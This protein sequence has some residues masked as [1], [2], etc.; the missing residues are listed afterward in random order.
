MWRPPGHWRLAQEA[1]RTGA[2]IALF[3]VAAPR[4]LSLL[5]KLEAAHPREPHWYLTDMGVEPRKQ[6]MGYGKA[7]MMHRLKRIDAQGAPAYLETPKLSNVEIY[8]SWGFRRLREIEAAPG[9]VYY[10]MWREPQG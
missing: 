9:L 7:V 5:A 8:Q 4:A 10:T 2:V 3:G 6:G 1:A